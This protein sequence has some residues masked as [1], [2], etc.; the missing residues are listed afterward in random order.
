MPEKYVLEEC[1]GI[2]KKDA[3][4]GYLGHSVEDPRGME[5]FWEEY[6]EA[7]EYRKIGFGRATGDER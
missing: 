7:E 6:K 1:C 2:N 5:S 3:K 4:D